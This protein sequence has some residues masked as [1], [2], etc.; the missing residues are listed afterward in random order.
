M[1]FFTIHK[2]RILRVYVCFQNLLSDFN[3]TN[4]A[5][6]TQASEQCLGTG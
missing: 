4:S 1:H 3:Q 6:T 2:I 5:T